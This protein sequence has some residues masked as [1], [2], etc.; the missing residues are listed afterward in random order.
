MR[1]GDLVEKLNEW[2]K[3]IHNARQYAKNTNEIKERIPQINAD[4]AEEIDIKDK[5]KSFSV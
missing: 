3:V 5:N 1:I 4:V 2:R